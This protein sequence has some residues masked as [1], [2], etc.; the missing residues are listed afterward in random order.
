MPVTIM[1][2]DAYLAGVTEL[3][4]GEVFGEGLFSTL[5]ASCKDEHAY[6]MALLLQL[7]GEAKVRL[8]PLLWRH[9]LSVVE[10]EAERAAGIE[11]A[12]RMQP[13]PWREA[14]HE[15]AALVMRYLP[16]YEALATAAPDSDKPHVEYMV[17]HELTVLRF[18]ELAAAGEDTAAAQVVVSEL[19]HP[20]P[21][22]R[23][24]PK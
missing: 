16:R 21:A 4:Q 12:L 2:N 8:R 13:L 1:D 24:P 23:L 11:A 3:Y 20:W 14:M 17:N 5:L 10:S 22:E 19:E 18:A 9:G 7:E 6:G 15:L